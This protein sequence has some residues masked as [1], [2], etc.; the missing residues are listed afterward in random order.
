MYSV[1]GLKNLVRGVKADVVKI[2]QIRKYLVNLGETEF[3]RLL[4]L[5][6][7]FRDYPLCIL[8]F[9]FGI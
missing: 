5:C 9:S 6:E 2:A 1:K 7:D 8:L 4:I 3:L